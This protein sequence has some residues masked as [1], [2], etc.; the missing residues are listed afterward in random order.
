[1]RVVQG[2]CRRGVRSEYFHCKRCK[3]CYA[4]SQEKTHTCTENVLDSDCPICFEFLFS[5][6]TPVHFLRC[7]HPIHL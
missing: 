3:A 2:I 5:S 7:G 1:M 4:A 6:T